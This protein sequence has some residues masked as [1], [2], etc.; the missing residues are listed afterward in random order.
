M[1]RTS[2]R[3]PVILYNPRGESHILPLALLHVGSMLNDRKVV[4]VD[5]RV[6]ESP[7]AR[8]A[9]LATEAAC[10]GV[11]VLTGAPIVDA[12]VREDA[13]AVR[14]ELRMHFVP[15]DYYRRAS[16][17]ISQPLGKRAAPLS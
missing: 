15:T 17:R 14:S 11:T 1:K 5:G 6:D 13:D 7:E 9:E 10:L 8:G 16:L 4:I 2:G 12:L 3:K